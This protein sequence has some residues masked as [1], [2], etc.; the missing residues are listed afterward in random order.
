MWII[1]VRPSTTTNP[2][3]KGDKDMNRRLLALFLAVMFVLSFTL[4]AS[5][6][7][8][9]NIDVTI[10]NLA[11]GNPSDLDD[12][13]SVAERYMNS[14]IVHEGV[15]SS[16]D[17]NG[18]I[19]IT[20]IIS[21]PSS[22]AISTNSKEVASSTIMILDANG[23]EITYTDYNQTYGGSST[24]EVYATH[25]TYYTLIQDSLIDGF[26]IKVSRMCTMFTFTGSTTP[27]GFYQKYQGSDDGLT[28]YDYGQS[29]T[30]YAPVANYSYWYYPGGASYAL[31][32]AGHLKTNAIF[33]VAGTQYNLENLVGLAM[34]D[35]THIIS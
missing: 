8:N 22:R 26:E 14:D 20:Q 10:D 16:I 19:N 29:S 28:S 17:Q 13:V 6:S 11:V 24:Y 9:T 31:G 27:T 34:S 4:P 30:T 18:R 5:A 12:V 7:D 1:F 23:D 32:G 3:T 25:T 33:T 21:T 15:T 35:W 2:H